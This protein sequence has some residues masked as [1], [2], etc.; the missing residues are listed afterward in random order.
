MYK[1]ENFISGINSGDRE[2]G[3]EDREAVANDRREK[4]K[5]GAE[6][7]RRKVGITELERN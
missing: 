1:K 3:N 7:K 4:R 5:E 2:E 6:R